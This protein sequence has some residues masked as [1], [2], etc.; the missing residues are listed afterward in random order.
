[1]IIICQ[2]K[3][4]IANYY[5]FVLFCYRAP[6]KCGDIIRLQHLPTGKNLHSHYFQSP[7][8]GNQEI[9][10]YGEDGT[11]DILYVSNHIFLYNNLMVFRFMLLLLFC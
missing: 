6:I 1:M 9:S 11:C 3:I 2:L 7:L 8:S 4:T 10:A 5:Y